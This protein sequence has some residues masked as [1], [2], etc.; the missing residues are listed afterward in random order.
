LRLAVQAKSR[1]ETVRALLGHGTVYKDV[2]RISDARAFYDR[3]SRRAARTGRRRQAAVARH[4]IFALQAEFGTLASGLEEVHQTLNL[5]PIHDR[6]VPYLAHD[7]A[8]LLI[9]HGLFANALALLDKLTPA[10]T[11]PEERLLV[12][13][14][15]A[16]AA[17]A[18][19][20]LE[21][22]RRAERYVRDLAV[23]YPEY[24]AAGLIHLAHAARLNG[25]WSQ[26]AAYASRAGE[27][28]A[29]RNDQALLAEASALRNEIAAGTPGVRTS[30]PHDADALALMDKNFAIRLRRWLAPDRRGT[31]ASKRA[32]VKD[33]ERTR[34]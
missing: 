20:R 30:A 11:K 2:G 5:Y 19:G 26:A 17:A 6:R 9:R 4:Y 21:R 29:A 1:H 16:W 22:Y 7:Y 10:I 23:A 24:A 12:E 31:G 27:I 13:S 28:A 14:N 8:F 15:V 3:A 32:S 18:M 25:E 34:L 33:L